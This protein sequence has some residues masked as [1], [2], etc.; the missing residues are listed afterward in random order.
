MEWY[1]MLI[2]LFG[3]FEENQKKEVCIILL[4]VGNSFNKVGI[5]I[6]FYLEEKI[7]K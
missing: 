5:F 4:W 2:D 7:L 6:I 1:K 3:G